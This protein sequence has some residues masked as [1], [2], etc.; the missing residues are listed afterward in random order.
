[1]WFD[2]DLLPG[3]SWSFPLGGGRANVGFGIP[4]GGSISTQAMKQLWPE[5][6]ARPHVRAVLGGS[7][8][9]EAP[10]KAWPIPARIGSLPLV[11]DRALFVGDAAGATDRLTGEGIGQALLTGT[12]AA[13]AC[14]EHDGTEARA[15]GDA[16]TRA[17]RRELLPDHWMSVALGKI[18]EH[19]NGAR[20]AIRIAGSSTWTRENFARWLFEDEPR[21]VV[22]TPRRWH[23]RFLDRDGAFAR[24]D[25][26]PAAFTATTQSRNAP[27][28]P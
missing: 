21:G 10:H 26:R 3:Y 2:R 9:A 7:A 22:L 19:P 11:A 25:H 20:A 17:V 24:A 27:S 16:Y 8:V 4:R 15:I 14:L 13:E 28:L 18:V 12:L 1:V 6:L 5:L 23:R